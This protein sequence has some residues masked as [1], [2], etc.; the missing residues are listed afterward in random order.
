MDNVLHDY[1]RCK[2]N[3]VFLKAVQSFGFKN[4]ALPRTRI[5]AGKLLGDNDLNKKGCI[6]MLPVLN[7]ISYEKPV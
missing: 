5:L 6:E 7:P 2:A 1:W 4:Y 3:N